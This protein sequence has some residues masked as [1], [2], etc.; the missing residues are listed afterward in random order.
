MRIFS[1]GPKEDLMPKSP[2]YKKLID[3]TFQKVL[4]PLIREAGFVNERLIEKNP[5]WINPKSTDDTLIEAMKE[6]F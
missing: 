1:V 4:V 5:D 3:R 2:G 6:L